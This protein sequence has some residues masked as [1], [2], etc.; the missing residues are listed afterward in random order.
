MSSL[1]AKK[2]ENYWYRNNYKKENKEKTHRNYDKNEAKK[3][4]SDNLRSN[5]EISC[6]S[7]AT[8]KNINN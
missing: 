8:L 3:I 1:K 5:R 4:K 6:N 2:S 7:I